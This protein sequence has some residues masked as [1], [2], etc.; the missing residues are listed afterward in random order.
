MYCVIH[1]YDDLRRQRQM[2]LIARVYAATKDLLHLIN[3]VLK[4]L[5]V[6]YTTAIRPDLLKI[7]KKTYIK[8]TCFWHEL[9]DRR[10]CH[11]ARLLDGASLMCMSSSERPALCHSTQLKPHRRHWGPSLPCLSSLEHMCP[12][13][14]ATNIVSR[15]PG[16]YR[17][18]YHINRNILYKLV[19][20]FYLKFCSSRL[21][22]S[23]FNS[24]WSHQKRLRN[25]CT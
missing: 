11:P 24:S 8:T 18:W 14:S 19:L 20:N 3:K 12:L 21:G 1:L 7:H 2:C 4:S 13:E 10:P 17:Y 22:L 15:R 23:R 25:G 16:T 6:A 5:V 9:L